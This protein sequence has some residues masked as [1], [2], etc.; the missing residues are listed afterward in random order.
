MQLELVQGDIT[1]LRVDAIV[2]AA[3][4]SLFGGGGVDGAIHKKGGR[5]NA[6]MAGM[7]ASLTAED[8]EQLAAYY[9]KQKPALETLKVRNYAYEAVTKK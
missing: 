6:I 4:P 2:N 9:S 8:I 3:N 1:A 7:A 5:K